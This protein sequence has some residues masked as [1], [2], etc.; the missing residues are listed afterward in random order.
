M[1]L[2]VRFF[3]AAAV[4]DPAD[5]A[6]CPGPHYLHSPVKVSLPLTVRLFRMAGGRSKT[7]TWTVSLSPVKLCHSFCG[8]VLSDEL[9]FICFATCWML[10]E[11]Q[12]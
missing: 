1:F 11:A 4:A 8:L 6:I 5:V 10:G 2:S 12:C 9:V 3:V 7:G